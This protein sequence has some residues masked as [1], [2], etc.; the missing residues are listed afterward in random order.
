MPSTVIY[1]SRFTRKMHPPGFYVYAYLDTNGFP[2]YIGKGQRARAWSLHE[3][4]ALPDAQYIVILESNLTEIGAWAIERRLVAIHGRVDRGSGIL[5]NRT[6]GGPG[7][8]GS[9]TQKSNEQKRK[10]SETLKAKGKTGVISGGGTKG[11]IWVN[12]GTDQQYI[13]ETSGIPL[14]YARGKIKSTCS[15][16]CG[17]GNSV[18]GKKCYTNGVI[19]KFYI[20]GGQPTKWVKGR[21]VRPFCL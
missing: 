3:N 18:Y 1:A 16:L 4:V 17:E 7:C 5:L 11:R 8:R 6:V 19:N 13:F 2:Y 14:G 15:N 21:T 20:E 10:I 9:R 12:N